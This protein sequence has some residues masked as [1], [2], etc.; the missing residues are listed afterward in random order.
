MRASDN[1][2]FYGDFRSCH[3]IVNFSKILIRESNI[4]PAMAYH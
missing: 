4:A 3:P 1:Y 2:W